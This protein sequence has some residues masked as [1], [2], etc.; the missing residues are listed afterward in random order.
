M[1]FQLILGHLR[2][3]PCFLKWS[4]AV[5]MLFHFSWVAGVGAEIEQSSIETVE[6]EAS[7]PEADLAESSDPEAGDMALQ[8]DGGESRSVGGRFEGTQ[9]AEVVQCVPQVP[10][11]ASFVEP[12]PKASG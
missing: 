5:T 2:L 11:E 4:I 9:A 6:R 8:G 1:P 3:F 10:V 12:D 7:N